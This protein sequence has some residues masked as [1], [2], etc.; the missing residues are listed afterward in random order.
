MEVILKVSL[1]DSNRLPQP[2]REDP[3]CYLQTNPSKSKKARLKI[4]C[5]KACMELSHIRHRFGKERKREV[6]RETERERD[7]EAQ[8]ETE[9]EIDRQKEIERERERQRER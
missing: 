2:S 5:D 6:Q 4:A 3:E 8:K 1:G 7:K 9:R